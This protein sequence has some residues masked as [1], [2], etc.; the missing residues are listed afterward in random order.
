MQFTVLIQAPPLSGLHQT[1][2]AF[3]ASLYHQGHDVFRVFFYQDGVLAANRHAE[4]DDQSARSL[5]ASWAALKDEYGF[6]MDVCI[7]AS[8]RRGITT[9]I[10]N[11][12]FEIVGLGQL[13]EAMEVADRTVA[14]G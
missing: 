14:F 6:E 2:Q 12:A 5:A 4:T 8:T 1:A 3:I 7:A 10:A 11:D 9:D 13:V